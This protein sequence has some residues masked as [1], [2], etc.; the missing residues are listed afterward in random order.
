MKLKLLLAAM[1]LVLGSGAMAAAISLPSGPLYFQFSNL[2]QTALGVDA[3]GKPLNNTDTCAGCSH[4]AE[5]N[6]GIAQVSV[7]RA[8]KPTP[9]GATPGQIGNDIISAGTAPFF[10]DQLLP[11]AGGQVTAIFYG[12]TITNIVKSGTVNSLQST[13]GFIDLYWDDPSLANTIVNL[14]SLTPGM[15]ID[16]SHYTGVTDGVFLARLA[17]SSGINPLSPSTTIQGTIDTALTGDS[18]SA[19][20]YAQV[21]DV[22]G[23]GV[24]NALDGMWAGQLNSDWFGT[25]FGRRDIRFSNKIQ[26]NSNWDGVNGVFGQS[27][28]DPGRGFVP[29]PA[30]L[31]LLSLGLLGLGA[32]RRRRA[33]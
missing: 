15:R 16:D 2:E 17:F 26:N 22:N 28:S 13:G 19:D 1:G 20:S 27:S 11:L 21:A 12:S 31:A 9:G 7:M 29:E 8:G 24:I 30:S 14:G 5:G 33:I 6:W 3:S 4:K 10:A 23:D 25:V 32:A 18:G